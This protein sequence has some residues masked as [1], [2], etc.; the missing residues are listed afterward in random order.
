MHYTPYD[1]DNCG[2]VGLMMRQ[3]ENHFSLDT[4][5]NPVHASF[6]IDGMCSSFIEGTGTRVR[7]GLTSREAIYIL[8]FL[9]YSAIFIFL[10]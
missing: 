6:D 7:Y 8:Q 1:I 2:G 9:R 10:S 3:I 4:T 5:K